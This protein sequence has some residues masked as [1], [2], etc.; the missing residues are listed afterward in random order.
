[1]GSEDLAACRQAGFDVRKMDQS[2]LD[3][4]DA[5]FDLLW[6]RHCLEHSI[7]PYFTLNEFHRV[8]KPGGMLYVEVPACDTPS[9]H[10]NHP[11]HY[12][13]LGKSMWLKLMTCSGFEVV[14][15]VDLSF[16]VPA[17][18][19]TYWAFIL[20]S[21]TPAA[22][23]AAP[24][25]G[26]TANIQT[27]TPAPKLSI[28]I[29]TFNRSRY[30][31]NALTHLFDEQ[32]F[33]FEFEVLV[34]DNDSTDGTHEL[35]ESFMQSHRQLRYI[36]QTRNVGGE[37]N[38]VALYRQARGE[39]TTYLADD[40]ILLPKAL[41]RVIKY[42]DLHPYVGVSF[43]TPDFWNDVENVFIG[44][45]YD[46][47][48]E[49]VFSR[50]TA[51]SLCN[52]IFERHIT[53]EIC[54]YRSEILRKMI[55]S[56]HKAYWGFVNMINALGYADVAFLPTIYYRSI[57]QHWAG[58]G[59]EQAG[60]AQTMDEWD[61][62]RGGLEYMVQRAFKYAGFAGVPS[63]QRVMTDQLVQKFVNERMIVALRLLIQHRQ[64]LNAYEVLVR[65]LA[66]DALTESAIA[67]CRGILVGRAALQAFINT[68][69]AMTG[70]RAIG[71]FHVE[72]PRNVH[73]LIDEL[74]ARL[75][76]EVLDDVNLAATAR[77][78]RLL[79]LAGDGAHRQTLIDAGFPP[80]QVWAEG[81][82][83][84]QYLI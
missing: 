30:L 78:D 54:V 39:Y 67:E 10:H 5:E 84:R 53:P 28:C 15:L 59:R 58:E 51:V 1:M 44:Q 27:R 31:Q 81:D 50:A 37:A 63:E 34:S 12:S 24:Q 48:P 70:V 35:V 60:V 76:V 65:L 42:L 13:V 43:C 26:P 6:C 16:S 46:S 14:E 21:L 11:N 45:G 55:Y 9:A 4:G 23:P 38:I 47:G 2:F 7:F 79:V 71:L 66:N 68:F 61:V 72:G 52:Y 82:L 56:P 75:P 32:R 57:T 41:A 49:I 36:R 22:L 29:P 83:T 64:Y 80:G 20:R 25:P 33:P 40:D 18:P 3:F 69:H 19:D 62:Y 77:K 74:E 73:A 17:G 8:L